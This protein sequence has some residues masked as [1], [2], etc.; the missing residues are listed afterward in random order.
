MANFV[1]V[2]S[3]PLGFNAPPGSANL[4]LIALQLSK[5]VNGDDGS[6]H[7]P[8]TPITFGGAGLD[9]TGPLT[10]SDVSAITLGAAGALTVPVG[11]QIIVLGT[12]VINAGGIVQWQSGSFLTVNAGATATL[13][14]TTTASGT[15]NASGTA[16]FSGTPQLTGATVF[17]ISPARAYTRTCKVVA[18]FDDAKWQS[19]SL[20]AFSYPL[21]VLEA[22]FITPGSVPDMLGYTLDVPDGATITS[23]TACVQG[24]TPNHLPTDRPTVYLYRC[25]LNT[26]VETL[27]GSQVDLSATGADYVTLHSITISGLSEVVD[28]TTS[29]YV[30]RVEGEGS[31][32]GVLGLK[33]CA[34]TYTFTRGK[35][36]EE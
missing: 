9:V 3:P 21:I 6:V 34:P 36:G 31:T 8:I 30:V 32:G 20:N 26:G 14:G 24:N 1:N 17:G 18:Y 23:V 29:T 15:F 7:A 12:Q 28:G 25:N 11:S 35:L 22:S 5:A 10:A 33:V 27:I 16:S 19:D 13:A 2:Y 4:N